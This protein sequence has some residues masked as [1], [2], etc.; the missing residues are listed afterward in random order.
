MTPKDRYDTSDLPEDQY[1]PGS[2]GTV[3]KNLLGITNRKELESVE[4]ERFELLMEKA[5]A[6]FDADHRF[7]AQDILWFIN[8]VLMAYLPG[9]EPIAAST[10]ARGDSCSR[11]PP[12]CRN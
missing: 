8:P 1:E 9:P 4:E 12:T 11:R 2:D 7:T 6:R 5:V 3:L 10:S